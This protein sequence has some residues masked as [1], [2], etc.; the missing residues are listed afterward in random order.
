MEESI[1]KNYSYIYTTDNY[2]YK[3]YTFILITLWDNNSS[4]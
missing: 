2:D 4:N 1:Y 3:P